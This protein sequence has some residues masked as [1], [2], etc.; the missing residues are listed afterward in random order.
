MKKL[1][2]IAAVAFFAGSSDA[3]FL[4][5]QVD[6]GDYKGTDYVTGQSLAELNASYA[7]VYSIDSHA[8]ETM[9]TISDPITGETTYNKM[10]SIGTGRA[11]INLDQIGR[12]ASYSFYIELVN[13]NA[14]TGNFDFVAKSE[15]FTYTQLQQSNFIDEGTSILPQEKV[16]HGGSYTATPEPTSAML[17]MM[18]LGLLALKRKKA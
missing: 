10:V 8:S 18:G 12:D 4:Y 1:L 5:W 7:R 9:L 2:A 16:W 15:T 17:V 13:Y 11:V 6:S 3:A 14:D